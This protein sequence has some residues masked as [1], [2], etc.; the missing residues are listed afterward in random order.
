[1]AVREEFIG[2]LAPYFEEVTGL[3]DTTTIAAIT[4]MVATATKQVVMAGVVVGWERR[5]S[6][7]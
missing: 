2:R 6:A 5:A 7:A 1:V 4:T 3:G